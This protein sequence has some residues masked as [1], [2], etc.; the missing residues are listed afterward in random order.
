MQVLVSSDHSITVSEDLAA[1]I[2][3]AVTDGLDRFAPRITRVNVHL[4]DVSSRNLGMADKHCVLEARVGGLKPIAVHDD[5]GDV[6]AVVD[7]AVDKLWRAP[8]RELGRL[9]ELPGRTSAECEIATTR[10]LEDLERASALGM[11]AAG[12]SR[13][14]RRSVKGHRWGS[15]A[16]PP[17]QF[18]RQAH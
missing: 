12:A 9:D 17:E 5:A 11:R 13:G 7:G 10:E 6:A 2:T 8:E 3:R 1:R 16:A 4:S 15:G 14:R 18:P